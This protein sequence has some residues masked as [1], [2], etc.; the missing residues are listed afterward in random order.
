MSLAVRLGEAYAVTADGKYGK[1][2][3]QTKYSKN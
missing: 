3:F 2:R 1:Q